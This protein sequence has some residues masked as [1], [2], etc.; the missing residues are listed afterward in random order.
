MHALVAEQS[1]FTGALNY[2]NGAI[3][4]NTD[5]IKSAADTVNLSVNPWQRENRKKKLE[6]I[7]NMLGVIAKMDF[8]AEHNG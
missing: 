4:G 2:L 1:M 6:Q 7:D 3:T 8:G 5:L